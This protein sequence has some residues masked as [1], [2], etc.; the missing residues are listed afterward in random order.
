MICGCK[1]ANAH[2][3]VYNENKEIK[4]EK[5]DAKKTIFAGDNKGYIWNIT[6][7]TVD[8]FACGNAFVF[9]GLAF[10][11]G[12]IYSDAFGRSHFDAF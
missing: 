2:F 6:N 9:A 8:F 4:T 11:G 5:R 3:W 10:Y 7:R 1:L 12:F